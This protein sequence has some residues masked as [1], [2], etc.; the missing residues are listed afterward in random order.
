MV[1]HRFFMFVISFCL[2]LNYN[3]PSLYLMLVFCGITYGELKKFKMWFR[4]EVTLLHLSKIRAVSH[5][6]TPKHLHKQP[7]HFLSR[8]G[9]AKATRLPPMTQSGEEC[10]QGKER[11]LG[12]C[13]VS[14]S[15]GPRVDRLI[16]ATRTEPYSYFCFLDP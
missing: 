15:Y 5:S 1:L 3:L 16:I 8:G 14:L 12:T 10:S 6:Y 2:H 4:Y 13:P 11:N 7:M 9:G